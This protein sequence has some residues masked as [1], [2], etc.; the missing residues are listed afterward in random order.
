M[1][2]EI[3]IPTGRKLLRYEEPITFDEALE[4]SRLDEE[5][6][7]DL[8]SLSYAVT[9]KQ[10]RKGVYLCSI[11]SAKTGACPE[12]CSFC[13]QSVHNKA[14]LPSHDLLE[15]ERILSE[16]LE[17]E[18]AGAS[19]FCIVASGRGPDEGTLGK[20]IEA[21]SLI[22]S[23]T[24]LSIGCSLGTLTEEQAEELCRAGVKRYNHNLET[25]RSFFPRICSTHTYDERLGTAQLVKEKGMELCSG[26]II[27]L[28]ESEEQRLE[29]AFELRTLNPGSVPLNFLNP[30]PNTPLA[31]APPLSAF[32]AL[33][34]I[35]LFRLILPKHILICA[36]GRE[37]I[38]K[39]LQPLALL[40]GAN[41]LI[42]GN[43]LTTRGAL[44]NQ[45][46]EMIKALDLGLLRYEN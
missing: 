43:Y 3:L 39:H 31:D 38:L 18:A 10:N 22:R 25:S 33:K 37:S 40:A 42:I 9:A 23:R 28:G 27:G 32:E 41:A 30:R 7:L 44:A 19:E 45:D 35:A 6:L 13:A 8:L 24:S 21:V 46:L 36:G 12:D 29:L 4:L 34:A 2:P 11:I 26:G 1:I 14:P 17:A 15:P 20:V 16:A 5:H